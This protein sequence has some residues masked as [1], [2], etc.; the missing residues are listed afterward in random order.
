MLQRIVDGRTDLVFDYFGD[1]SNAVVEDAGG[2][3]LIRW[4]AYYGD[5]S[6]IRF[7]MSKGHLL[8]ALGENIGPEYDIPAPDVGTNSQTMAWMMDTYSNM[9]GAGSKQSVKGVVT[10]KPVASGGTLGRAKATGQGMVFCV[11]EWS[12][13]KAFELEGSTIECL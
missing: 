7:L 2:V 4:C 9:G 6:A 1:G 10:G 8:T 5:V 3:P 11:I 13:E 12:K